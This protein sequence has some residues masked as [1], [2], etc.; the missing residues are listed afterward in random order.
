MFKRT[1]TGLSKLVLGVSLT[2]LAQKNVISQDSRTPEQK[3]LYP[4]E[5][6]EPVY[7]EAYVRPPRTFSLKLDQVVD[8]SSQYRLLIAND[9]SEREL[10]I[11][12]KEDRRIKFLEIVPTITLPS[13]KRVIY[14]L[15]PIIGDWE[16]LTQEIKYER[17]LGKG[18]LS[19]ETN[20]GYREVD[21]GLESRGRFAIFGDKILFYDNDRELQAYKKN[22]GRFHEARMKLNGDF[23]E[24]VYPQTPKI[25]IFKKIPSKK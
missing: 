20:G 22:Q 9:H 16:Q 14:K 5:V 21:Q 18:K 4:V 3:G 13:P 2:L 10:G 12:K 15:H 7:R 1:L 17:F 6:V 23:L 8:Q 19:L 25:I 11:I 24:L